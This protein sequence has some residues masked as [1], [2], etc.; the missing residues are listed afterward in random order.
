MKKVDFM[1]TAFRDGLQSVYGARVL[2]KD[3]LPIIKM[4]H[5]AGIEHLEVG[6]GALFQSPF[7]YTKEN[8]FEIMDN[9]RSTVGSSA[10]LQTLARGVSVVAL[11]SQSSDIIDLHA[12]LFKKHGMTT[13][14][15]FDALN[16]VENLIFSGQS[17][18]NAGLKHEVCIT[19]MS[20]P[21][22]TSGA[23]DADFYE[24]TLKEIIKS[25]IP[26]DS[27]CFKDASGTSTPAVIYE[28]IK[29]ARKILGDSV[30]IAFHSHDT[31][32]TC[33]AQYLAAVEAGANQ[34][35]LSLA[36]VSGGTCQ[37]DLL[38]MWHALRYSDYT[39]DIDPEKIL[40]LE[41]AFTEAMQDYFLPPEAKEVNP[42]I[43]FSP[44]P[45]GALTANTQMLRD[46]DLMDKFP[47]ITRAMADT[48]KRGG[49]GTSV[50]PVSQ[51][52]FQ[53]AF[54]NV[55][56]GDWQKIVDGYGKMIL[57]YFGKTP[58]APDPEIVKL[59]SEQLNLPVNTK[60][61]LEINDA[62]PQLRL[63]HYRDILTKENLP[64][65][66]ENIFI[67]ASCGE[68][69]VLFLKGASTINVRKEAKSAITSAPTLS[70]DQPITIQLDGESFVVEINGDQATVNGTTYRMNLNQESAP[71]QPQSTKSNTINAPLPGLILKLLKPA[72]ATVKAGEVVLIMEAMKMES[73][74]KS[75]VDGTIDQIYVQ[76]T[77]QV[78]SGDRL[79]SIKERG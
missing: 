59:A 1:C 29:R 52:Y 48:V 46:N 34:V 4:A 55:M 33:I 65:T 18:H 79:F 41:S 17:I 35:D 8:A 61:V 24:K 56:H 68:K 13:I 32:G 38:S 74:I 39:L 47:Q 19:M 37:S 63:P 40:A 62:N 57:G 30:K 10:N 64:T 49:F 15:N 42:I 11:T 69:G 21:V 6:G 43:P 14:R 22:G 7:F 20:L 72:G 23:H 66:D 3:V 53:Q 70:S 16:D 71:S 27:L 31:A 78:K 9:I 54:N 75:H 67:I 28:T 12:K 50:T 44:L 2:S 51:F 26:F 25:Q 76:N 58:V 77:Q 36:P 73:P 60:K 45:G 5:E